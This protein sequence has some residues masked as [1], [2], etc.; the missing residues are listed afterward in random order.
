MIRELVKNE[1]RGIHRLVRGCYMLSKWWNGGLCRYFEAAVLPTEPVLE[2]ALRG[3]SPR[4]L[5]SCVVC[6]KRFP[7]AGRRVY[8]SEQCRVRG[9]RA[10]D[11][12][13]A[14]RYRQR[15]D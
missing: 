14:R 11:A 1:R 3:E 9:R 10:V 2:R 8:C 7:V 15:K 12:K 4:D 13:R 5:K 6:G